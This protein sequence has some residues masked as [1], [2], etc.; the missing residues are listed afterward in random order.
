[1]GEQGDEWWE[2]RGM[3]GGKSSGMSGW[4]EQRDEWVGRAE[5]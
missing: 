3:S 4:E 1:V 2:S 5:G